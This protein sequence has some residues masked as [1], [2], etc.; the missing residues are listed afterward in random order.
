MQNKIKKISCANDIL[1]LLGLIL[2][3]PLLFMTIAVNASIL[4]PTR[5]LPTCLFYLV[6]GFPCPGC[7]GTRA[8][9][10][11]LQGNFLTSFLHH[12][13]VPYCFFWYVLFMT[14]QTL[15][16]LNKWLRCHF[17]SH[18][19][20]ANIPNISGLSF[21]LSYVYI[22]V[23]IILVQWIVKILWQLFFPTL[24]FV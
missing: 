3:F 14:T 16:R 23:L 21:R 19:L 5:W 20:W 11:M 12:P 6:T 7:G 2:L 18:P 13:V 1:F 4:H 8:F 24:S 22:A 17:D 10:A 15:A 9:V